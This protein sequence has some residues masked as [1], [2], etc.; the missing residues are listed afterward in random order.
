VHVGIDARAE[1]ATAMWPVSSSDGSAARLFVFGYLSPVLSVLRP[2]C[3]TNSQI[4]RHVLV[5]F[6]TLHVPESSPTRINP[7]VVNNPNPIQS[8]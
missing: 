5:F 2:D 4:A 7:I 1:H 8:E 3:Q 6:T